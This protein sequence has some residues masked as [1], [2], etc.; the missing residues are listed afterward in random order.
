MARV[1]SLSCQM[2]CRS[3]GKPFTAG[4]AIP[5]ECGR[6]L[7]SGRGPAWR[8]NDPHAEALRLACHLEDDPAP[9]GG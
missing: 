2:H 4:F 1:C 8:S 5:Q 9:E 7:A 3:C 6:C